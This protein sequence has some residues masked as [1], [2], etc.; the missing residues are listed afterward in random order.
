MRWLG[1]LWG[2]RRCSA[3]GGSGGS[4]AGRGREASSRAAEGRRGLPAAG[5]ALGA[6]ARHT[7]RPWRPPSLGSGA[8]ACD[9]GIVAWWPTELLQDLPARGLPDE[10]AEV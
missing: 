5:K 3:V 9:R 1:L 8:V 10:R 6:I 2:V 7:P 4:A